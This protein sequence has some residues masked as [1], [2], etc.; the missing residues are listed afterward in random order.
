MMTA[1]V[2]PKV[3]IEKR[4]QT[5]IAAMAKNTTMTAI[6]TQ[7]VETVVMSGL[8]TAP[9]SQTE[10]I[11][12]DTR[13][14][15]REKNMWSVS[16]NDQFYSNIINLTLKRSSEESLPMPSKWKRC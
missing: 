6:A 3:V 12:K 14:N 7:K 16:L 2:T 11:V 15:P 4:R 10:T 5:D 13:C 1:T 9:V 8:H